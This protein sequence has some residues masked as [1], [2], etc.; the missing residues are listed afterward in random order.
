[1]ALRRVVYG[2]TAVSS[3][4]E[5]ELE[6][7]LHDARERNEARG[8]S[9]ILLYAERAF[10]QVLEGPPEAVESLVRNIVSDDRHTGVS[11]LLD[12]EIEERDFPDWNMGYRRLDSIADIPG[13]IG[14]MNP[15]DGQERDR[16]KLSLDV[17]AIIHGFRKVTRAEGNFSTGA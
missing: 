1:M 2:S 9:G 15:N 13:Y 5:A 10:L 7:L 14:W 8:I 11:V 17:R 3:F 12:E 4:D 16:A 6:A